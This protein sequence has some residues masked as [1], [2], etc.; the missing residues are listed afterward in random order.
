[1]ITNYSIT[2]MAHILATTEFNER[3]ELLD[4]RLKE[5]LEMAI[6][7]ERIGVKRMQRICDRF[8]EVL[9]NKQ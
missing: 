6:G 7:E 5:A 8:C 4:T 2:N 3:C 9:E 1:M